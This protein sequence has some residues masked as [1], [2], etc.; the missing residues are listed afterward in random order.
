MKII[1]VIGKK[2]R[3]QSI[4]MQSTR[5]KILLAMSDT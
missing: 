4:I 3:P 1:M 2:E 5:T